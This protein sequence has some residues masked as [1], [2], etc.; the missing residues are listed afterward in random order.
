MKHWVVRAA[1]TL[2]IV[3]V[4][5]GCAT[6]RIG[7]ES[8]STAASEALQKQT[9]N[10]AR[11]LNEI[12]ATDKPVHGAVLVL[13]PSDVEIQTSYLGWTSNSYRLEKERVDFM[14]AAITNNYQFI[15]DVTRKRGIFDTVGIER[16]NGKPASF[17]IGNYDY[18][19][20]ADVDGWFI[21]G[22][23]DQRMLPIAADASQ[24]SG[25]P[26]TLSFLESLSRQVE[27]LYGK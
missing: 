20:F 24:P 11:I 18:V 26:R 2:I 17:P 21:R 12:T 5:G 10:F 1:V 16:H 6:H 9:E 27:A 4:V 7:N 13:F 15:A 8:F 25:A 23:G 14:V 22:R 3:L 19:L